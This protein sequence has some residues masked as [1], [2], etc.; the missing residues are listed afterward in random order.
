MRINFF[1]SVFTVIVEDPDSHSRLLPM[2]NDQLVQSCYISETINEGH[3]GKL[4]LE[5]KMARK[6]L[7]KIAKYAQHLFHMIDFYLC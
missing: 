5:G 4:D 6:Q 7:A 3:K 2:E 1:G